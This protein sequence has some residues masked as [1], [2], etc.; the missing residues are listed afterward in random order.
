MH[1]DGEGPTE[2]LLREESES[3]DDAIGSIGGGRGIPLNP[4]PLS[5]R[6]GDPSSEESTISSTFVPTPTW[7][8]PDCNGR[9][10]T[11]FWHAILTF[12]LWLFLT[13]SAI[14]SPSLIDVL[15]LVGAF[16]GTMIAFILPAVF[17]L[18]LK[19]YSRISII[20]LGIG[21]TIGLFSFFRRYVSFNPSLK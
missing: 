13:I 1:G 10:L 15:D 14:K 4:S 18:K 3:D 21:G 5:S 19:G 9:Q 11:F 2:A 7:I 20:V 6:S 16:A 8:L 17:S 12:I